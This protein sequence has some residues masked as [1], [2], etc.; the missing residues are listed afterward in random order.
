MKRNSAQILTG[1]LL[2]LL[3]ALPP[4]AKT[5]HVCQYAC[6]HE[7]K[8][9]GRHSHTTHHDCDTCAIC[10]FVLSPFTETESIEFNFAVR[11]LNS[12]Q[13]TY[14]EN[15]NHPVEYSCMLRAPPCA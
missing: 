9:E 13:F 10:Q 14:W 2:L 3:F 4:A 15:I 8:H 6:C 5:V 12:E 7:T 11:T 1:L